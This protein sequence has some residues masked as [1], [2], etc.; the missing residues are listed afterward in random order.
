[1]RLR[2][3]DRQLRMRAL[4]PCELLAPLCELALTRGQRGA[5]LADPRRGL[6]API[7][8]G[9][10]LTAHLAVDPG[11]PAHLERA[12]L[13]LRRD[14]DAILLEAVAVLRGRHLGD[15]D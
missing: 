3:A 5:R 14:P 9:R 13:E 2:G 8:E 6:A 4:R 1:R 11:E 10:E 7:R 12:H 15:A